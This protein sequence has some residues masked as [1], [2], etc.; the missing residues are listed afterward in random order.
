MQLHCQV[1][2]QRLQKYLRKAKYQVEKL[3]IENCLLLLFLQGY[4]FVLKNT[5]TKTQNLVKLL[6][7]LGNYYTDK[8]ISIIILTVI[9]VSFRTSTKTLMCDDITQ[10]NMILFLKIPKQ[11]FKTYRILVI[12]QTTQKKIFTSSFQPIFMFHFGLA[13]KRYQINLKPFLNLYNKLEQNDY[14]KFC[15]VIILTKTMISFSKIPK[16]KIKSECRIQQ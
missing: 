8:N 6:L 14:R 2:R 9:Q 13:F 4:V 16:H 11:K 15:T 5:Q 1:L 10:Q 7:I 3:I 12:Q